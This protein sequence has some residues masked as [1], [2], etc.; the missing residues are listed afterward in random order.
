MWVMRVSK[1]NILTIRSTELQKTTRY[2]VNTGRKIG[3]VLGAPKFGI[4]A[5]EQVSYKIIII[6][7]NNKREPKS[8]NRTFAA[9]I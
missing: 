9:I 3:E 6:I 8:M 4:T 7:I 2:N 1:D 5:T